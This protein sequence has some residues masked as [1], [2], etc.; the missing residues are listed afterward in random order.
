MKQLPHITWPYTIRRSLRARSMRIQLTKGKP[1]EV[2]Y[3]RHS[4]KKAALAFLHSKVAWIAAQ[5]AYID[6]LNQVHTLKLPRLIE[7]PC[8]QK[9]FTIQ[10]VLEPDK[11]K[12]SITER[13][14]TLVIKTPQASDAQ[15]ITTLKRWLKRTAESELTPWLQAISHKTDLSYTSLTWRCQKTRWGS[16]NQNRAIN[17]NIKLLFLKKEQAQYVMYHE[18]CHTRHMHHNREFWS[19]LTH[20]IGNAKV[21]DREL[22]H[23]PFHHLNWLHATES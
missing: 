13:Q 4:S 3:P 21:I 1:I 12:P 7:L 16:C 6:S 17:L 20:F 23:Y 9:T 14:G 15:A 18:L 10:H 19:L 5:Q 11:K 8:L 22:Y 2:V